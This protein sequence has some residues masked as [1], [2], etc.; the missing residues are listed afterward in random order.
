MRQ[1][2][3]GSLGV[4][5]PV[6]VVPQFELAGQGTLEMV[7]KASNSRIGAVNDNACTHDTRKVA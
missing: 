2:S 1:S 7:F 4:V 3:E 6:T 5:T